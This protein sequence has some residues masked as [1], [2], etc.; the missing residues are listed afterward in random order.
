MKQSKHPISGLMALLLF[1]VFA[2]CILG[3]LLGATGIYQRLTERD[4]Q[5]YEMRTAAMY[6]ATKVRQ[7]DRAGGI[8]V[9][10]IGQSDALVLTETVEGETFRT[11]IYCYDDYLYELFLPADLE[12]APEDGERL[13]PVEQLELSLE[14]GLLSAQITQFGESRQLR[15]TLRSQE[16]GQ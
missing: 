14:D 15:L 2:I 13:L 9:E 12:A 16:V 11:W 10:Q 1:G 4:A 3:V 7:N 6:V 5:S 8:A